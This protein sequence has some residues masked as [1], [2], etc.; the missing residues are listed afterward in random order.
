[1]NKRISIDKKRLERFD[2]KPVKE[3][4]TAIEKKPEVKQK[5]KQDFNGTLKDQGIIIN[6]DFKQQIRTEW[7]KNIKSD[8]RRVAD[9]NPE[10]KKWY[11]KQVLSKEPIKLKVKIDKETGTKTKSLRRIR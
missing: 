6:E 7:R 1:M 8:I 9:E 5:L 11:L 3:L 10:S 4:K 2:F